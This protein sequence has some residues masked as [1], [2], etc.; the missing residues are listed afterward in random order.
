M[1]KRVWSSAL[2]CLRWLLLI[3]AAAAAGVALAESDPGATLHAKY[4]SLEEQLQRNQ[5]GRP[6]VLDSVET[7]NRLKGDIYAIVEYPLDAVNTGLNN[8]DHW[9]DVMLLHIN[10]KYCHALAQPA[11]AIL[12]V[13]IG[14]K[15]PEELADTE[16]IEFN[17]SV[18]AA[19]SE[20]VQIRLNAKDGPLGTSDY[21]IQLETMAL[22][23]AKTFLH[24]TYSYAMNFSARLAM[25]TYLGTIGSSKVGFTV[26]G[27]RADGQP[28]Y[29]GGVRGMVERN[30][31]RYFL[32]IDSFLGA[33]SAAPAAQ[34]EKRL[35]DWFTAVERYP[36][37]LH[38]MD[39]EQYLQ[40][41][42]AEYLRQ[43]TER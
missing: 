15:T 1:H 7:P 28:N 30:T 32:A 25:Q 26:I 34:F 2:S 39:R 13:N 41:K 10:T 35:Q 23:N 17:Y 36:R 29:V 9:C 22:P 21:H 4:A 27:K 24:L 14:K 31:M 6:L 42:R 19:T 40:M 38:E 18:A 11:G 5:F 33:A 43:Q 20:Y 12:R 37:Q 8:P 16:R 3:C